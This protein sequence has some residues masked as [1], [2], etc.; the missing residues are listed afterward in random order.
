MITVPSARTFK[1]N[2]REAYFPGAMPICGNNYAIDDG[3][4]QAV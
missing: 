1:T 4:Q 3:K 2:A